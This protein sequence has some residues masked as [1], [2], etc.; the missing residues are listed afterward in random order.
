[1]KSS[2]VESLESRSDVLFSPE[3]VALFLT[4]FEENYDLNDPEYVVWLRNFHPEADV[5]A[6]LS[7]AFSQ[8]SG[9]PNSHS[10]V[11]GSIASD[12]FSEAVLSGILMLPKAPAKSESKRKPALTNYTV[13]ITNTDVLVELKEEERGK[14]KKEEEKV[15]KRQEMERRKKAKGR[16]EKAKEERQQERGK[17]RGKKNGSRKRREKRGKRKKVEGRKGKRK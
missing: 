16:E 6:S 11:K 8:S 17:T 14:L 4:R 10:S 12:D 1:M 15:A 9:K 13:C 3:K 5:S 2:E 7:D